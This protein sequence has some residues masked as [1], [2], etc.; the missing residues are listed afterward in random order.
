MHSVSILN[1]LRQRA[2]PQSS[3]KDPVAVLSGLNAM[4]Q[5]DR[6]DDELFTMW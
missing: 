6:H 5:I 4:F 3:L 2:I 1:A